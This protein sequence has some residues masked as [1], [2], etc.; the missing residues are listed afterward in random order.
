[1]TQPVTP[2]VAALLRERAALEQHGKTDRVADVDAELARVGYQ[3]QDRH[4][5]PAE[6][7]ADTPTPRGRRRA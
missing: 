7:A 2:Y 5:P 4:A 1:M 6:T 3:P